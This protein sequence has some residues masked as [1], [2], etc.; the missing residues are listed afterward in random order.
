MIQAE[1]TSYHSTN[2]IASSAQPELFSVELRAAFK[3]LR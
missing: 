1:T 2:V 3:S